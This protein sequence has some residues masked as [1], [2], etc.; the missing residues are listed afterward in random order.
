[1]VKRAFRGWSILLVAAVV[2]FAGVLA[3]CRKGNGNDDYTGQEETVSQ[4]DELSA[5]EQDGGTK[6]FWKWDGD[7]RTLRNPFE[8]PVWAR[9]PEAAEPQASSRQ[10]RKESAKPVTLRLQGILYS[11]GGSK[12]LI[13]GRWVK[14]GDRIEGHR[15]VEIKRTSVLLRRRNGSLVSL[16]LDSRR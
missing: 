13:N 1:M 14:V 15:V 5:D 6:S 7:T 3:S 2:T 11:Q 12:A 4:A 16:S 9:R 10:R 8:R